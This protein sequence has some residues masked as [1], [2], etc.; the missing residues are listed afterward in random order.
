MIFDIMERYDKWTLNRAGLHFMGMG[1]VVS[2]LTIFTPWGWL[3]L[4]FP[5]FLELYQWKTD[6]EYKLSDG[7]WDFL[8]W[9]LGGVLIG[10]AFSLAR[11]I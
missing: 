3:S 10:G 4:I 7:I 2:F 1:L 5:L 6:S 8:E 9:E 11:M